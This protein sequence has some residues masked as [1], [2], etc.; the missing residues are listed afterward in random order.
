MM[1]IGEF[2][3]GLTENP[4]VDIFLYSHHL[5][6]WFCFDV[7]RPRRNSVLVTHESQMVKKT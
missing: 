2:D 1:S 3:I 5:S 7:V 6:S 4:L